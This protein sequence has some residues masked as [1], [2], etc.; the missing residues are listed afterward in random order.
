MGQ[1][2]FVSTQYSRKATGPQSLRL[3]M[4]LPLLLSVFALLLIGILFVYSSS[5][6]YVLRENSSASYILQRQ[7]VFIGIGLVCALIASRIDYHVYPRWVVIIMLITLASL[8]MVF[9]VG[10]QAPGVPTRALFKSSIQ[11]SELAK[12]VI[13]IYLAVWLN[14]H[15]DQLNNFTLGILPLLSIIGLTGGLI[16]MQPDIS[17]AITVVFLG[18]VLF[19]LAGSNFRQVVFALAIVLAVGTLFVLV[20]STGQERMSDYLKGLM[21]LQDA[22]DHVRRSLE[23]VVRGGVFG[24]GIGKGSTKYLG[25]PVPWTDSIF[26]VIAEETGLIGGIIVLGLF[27]VIAWR[28]IRISRNAPDLLGKIIAGG[29]TIWITIEALINIGVMVN[30]FPFAGNALPLVSY[31]GSS[32]VTTLTGVGILMNIARFG[33]PGSKNIEENGFHAAV[34]LRRR[35]RRRSV[36]RPHGT[37]S[38]RE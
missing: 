20:S 29:I 1:Q 13:I 4:D 33:K 31:G 12:L 21:S 19:F 26:A 36:S 37:A 16:F 17:A 15:H 24:V 9:I 3:K 38:T 8:I 23:A 6:N 10:S 22:S 11:P 25:L 14:N 34:D 35:D 7:L 18:G 5:W 30:V 32:M 2:S 27:M 28:G